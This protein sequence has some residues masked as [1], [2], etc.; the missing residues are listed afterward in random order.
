MKMAENPIKFN[1]HAISFVDVI[2]SVLCGT[3]STMSYYALFLFVLR[4]MPKCFTYGEASVIVQGIVIFLANIYF[5][6]IVIVAIPPDCKKDGIEMCTSLSHK[7]SRIRHSA[8]L[9]EMEQLIT[10]LQVK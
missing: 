7:S 4:R 10:I 9:S 6:L 8:H 5:E 2:F 1:V 3:I